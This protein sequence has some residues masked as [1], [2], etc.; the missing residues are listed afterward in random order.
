[1][2]AAELIRDTIP[3]VKSSDPTGVVLEWMNEF[4]VSQLPIVDDRKLIGII[5]EENILD[6]ADPSLPVGVAR[7]ISSP[8]AYVMADRYI[9]DVLDVMS[10]LHL[11]VLPVLDED[12]HYLGMITLRDI[13]PFFSQLFALHN[14]GSV[15]ILLIPPRGYSLSE[16]GRITEDANARV[17]SLY[18]SEL[19]K[20]G[21]M[22]LTLKLNLED[23]TPAIA[24]FERYQYKVYRIYTRQ[25]IVDDYSR[26]LDALLRYLNM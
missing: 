21:D 5:R 11:E 23:P 14:P 13:L 4:K 6:A 10:Q 3:P 20:E 1:M 12:M 25:E 7:D 15:L 2:T 18:F 8:S 19:N 9:Y 16:I 26:N 22:L 24:A 17:L